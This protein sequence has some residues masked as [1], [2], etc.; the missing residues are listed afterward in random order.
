MGTSRLATLFALFL[1]VGCGGSSSDQRTFYFVDIPENPE[2][3]ELEQRVAAL[4]AELAGTTPSS[5]ERPRL[6]VALASEL[7]MLIYARA[8]SRTAEPDYSEVVALYDDLLSNHAGSSRTALALVESGALLL[9]AG[10]LDEGVARLERVEREFPEAVVRP[11]ACMHLGDVAFAQGR[12]A[13]A[14]PLLECGADSTDSGIAS[15]SNYML[16]W[17]YLNGQRYN[18]AVDAFQRV[19][20]GSGDD[21]MIAAAER[22]T[23]LVFGQMSDGVERALETFGERPELLS[24]LLAY[25]ADLA[26]PE[27]ERLANFLLS[28][29]PEDVDAP[30]WCALWAANNAQ[31]SGS[32]EG[33]ESCR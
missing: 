9:E 29:Y 3:V 19:A 16:G 30:D 15:D 21:D 17:V 11:T 26:H 27:F 12:L 23:L 14:E 18:D 31:T 5:A 10:R 28:T 7:E 20:S 2:L 32:G 25:Y 22:D 6:L 13:A 4:R 8:Q 24:I 33:H 1:A